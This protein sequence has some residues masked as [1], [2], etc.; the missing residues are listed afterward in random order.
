[1]DWVSILL[2]SAVPIVLIGGWAN[3]IINNKGIGWQ[4]IRFTVIALVLPIIGLLAVKEIIAGDVV[5]ALIAAA[6]GY[7]FGKVGKDEQE[8]SCLKD[9]SPARV[10]S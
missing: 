2:A 9:R 4:F 7:A 5:Y 10:Y 1:M 8:L 6:L 3:R